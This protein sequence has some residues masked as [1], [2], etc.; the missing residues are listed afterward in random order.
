MK[1]KEFG[2]FVCL[3]ACSCIP[4]SK[5]DVTLSL[6]LKIISLKG[7]DPAAPSDTATLL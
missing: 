7:G 5:I 3:N 1:Y 2:F 6:D 4:V